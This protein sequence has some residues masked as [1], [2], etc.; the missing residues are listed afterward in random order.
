MMQPGSGDLLREE[1]AGTL[2]R[3]EAVAEKSQLAFGS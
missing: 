2:E 3:V 1:C